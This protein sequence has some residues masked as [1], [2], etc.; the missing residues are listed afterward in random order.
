LSSNTTKTRYEYC[1]ASFITDIFVY[2]LSLDEVQ[3]SLVNYVMNSTAIEV[4]TFHRNQKNQLM[5]GGV[6][7]GARLEGQK[8]Q[9]VASLEKTFEGSMFG[10]KLLLTVSMKTAKCR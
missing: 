3:F 5:N 8:T 7:R 6:C 4:N 9:M 2:D 1:T 10:V